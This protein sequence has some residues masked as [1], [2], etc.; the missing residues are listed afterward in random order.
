MKKNLTLLF[1]FLT[2]VFSAQVSIFPTNTTWKYLD[3]GTDQGTS[4]YAPGFNDLAWATGTAQLGYGESDEA[5]VLS[6][7]PSAS[8]KYVTHYFRKTFTVPAG[9]YSLFT[10]NYKVDDGFVVYVNG[11][12]AFRDNMATGAVNYTTLSTGTSD[13]GQTVR[14]RTVSAS[15]FSSGTNVIAVEVH[16]NALNS[17]DE[18][19]ELNLIGGAPATLTVPVNVTLFPAATTWKYMDDGTD[20]G[21]SWSAPAFNDLAWPTGT[22]QFGFGENDEATLVNACGTVVATPTCT[23]K[24]IT[25]YF[26]K[27]ISLASVTGY[28][29]YT[30]N[31]KRD[32]GI[33]V[34]VN[35]TEAFRSNM[36]TGAVNYT[37]WAS[38]A[39]SD[40]GQTV[41]TTTVP[42][43]TFS[44]GTN[45]IATELHNRDG[46]SSDATFEMELVANTSS[47]AVP[48]PTIVKGPYL[49]I[50][51]QN[52]M[53]IRW[54]TSSA[55]DT[56]VMYGTSA[57]SLTSVISNTSPVVSHEVSIGSLSAYTKYFYSIGTTSFV[58][59]GDTN[60]YFLTSPTPGAEGKYRFWV[61]G[62]CGNASTNQ[63]NVKNQ[64]KNYNGNRMVDGWLTLGD[65]AYSSGSDPQF[66]A[67]FFTIYQNDVM[68]NKVL[69]P[70]PGNHD[71]NNGAV[72]SSTTP[73][74]SIFNVPTA[75]EAGGVASGTK[76]YYSYDYGNI[77]FIALDSYGTV[78][79]NKM[80]DTTGAQAVWL[81]ADLAANTKK[82]IVA[83][84]HHP[85][86]TMG[87]HNSDTE[88]DLVAIRQKFIRIL[89]RY[90]VDLILCGHSHDYERSKLMQGHYG[91]ESTFTASVHNLSQSSALY[92]GSSNSCP[93]TKDSVNH[94]TGTVYVLS[95]SSGQ[96][97]GQQGS[98]PHDAMHYSNSTNGG[99]L[100]MD[101]EGNRLDLKW[102][103]A[104]GV[105]RDKFTIY[106]DVNAVKNYTVLPAQVA[107]L[108]ASWPGAFTWDDNSTAK[109]NTVSAL[110]DA[111]FWV[112]DPNSC[113]ADTFK[114]KVLPAVDFTATAPY[115]ISAPISFSNLSTNNTSVWTW[116]VSP[117]AGVLISSS[118]AQNPSITFGTA[119]IYTVSLIAE[120]TYGP[121]LAITKT[122]SVNANP[123]VLSSANATAI[124][125]NQSA[126]L[127][128]SGANSYVW[129]SGA[130]TSLVVV[131]PT[132]SATYTVTGTDLNGCIA[133]SIS[134]LVVNALPSVSVI[135]TPTS[136]IICSGGTLSLNGAGASS[137][138][139]TG[140][141]INGSTFTLNANSNYTLTGTDANGCENTA[142]V[143]IVV[144]ALPALS[145][146]SSPSTAMVCNGA[147][148]SIT[149]SGATSYSWNAGITNG[150]PFAPSTT[151][152]YTVTATDVNGCQNTLT[153]S[154]TVNPLPTVSVSGSS[155]ICIGQSVNLTAF[156][157][158]TYSWNTA[159]STSV[160]SV[161]PVTNSTYTLTGT[162]ANGC[163][164]V[165]L[166][167]ISVNVLPQV[168]ISGN[169]AVCLGSALTLSAGGA[170]SYVW[171]TNATTSSISVNPTSGTTYTVTG[172]DA[173]GCVDTE[174]KI[175]AVNAI[176]VVT[177]SGNMSLCAG[178]TTTLIANG[179]TTYLW[180]NAIAT[181]TLVSSPSAGIN[182]TVTG[183]DANG[184][185]NV[186]VT[187]FT[188]NALPVL[189]TL[190]NATLI[191]AGESATLTV[192]GASAYMWNT[193]ATSNSI[194]VSPLVNTTYSVTGKSPDNCSAS[195]SIVQ[196][197]SECTAVEKINS[198]IQTLI[199]PNPNKG[200]FNIELNTQGNFN[201]D[202]F[203]ALGERVYSAKLDKGTTHIALN[204]IKGIYFYVILNGSQILER[205]KIIIE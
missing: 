193:N 128:A 124:C 92:D 94:A 56:K 158:T 111:T 131:N 123:V 138:S 139:W 7:G 118:G 49:Q 188:V 83:Y 46:T 54:E 178:E 117:S 146:V 171:N 38:T 147:S 175:I 45:W 89:E 187:S 37:T 110:S 125:I 104:D 2:C 162:D 105:V 19:F 40:D 169:N 140:S 8:N 61:I 10:F 48:S 151:A 134:T 1:L 62:D 115:C 23:N 172:T 127:T 57:A 17:S 202:I 25:Q 58:I 143:A 67:E 106:K 166:K 174:M 85:P 53:K 119:G 114:L 121:G 122:I 93:Y 15:T 176:P 90:K 197:V 4:W 129:N 20:Q 80:Y 59:Q 190:S 165:A 60:N 198:N 51:T 70:V 52:S 76:A 112:K 159:A 200:A 88:S 177:L 97:G 82:W 18:T 84:W 100:V 74:F 185:S 13:D 34:Y 36:P 180:S 152:V 24:Y 42:A 6:Y 77:H 196:N 191:C 181:A 137:Y 201:A 160:I 69:W 141:I 113:V 81:K 133:S 195:T 116:S 50:G 21:T 32:D 78:A 26:R 164:N 29:A 79:G 68:K 91:A 22:A 98:F 150:V 154:V 183:T 43:N 107:T 167:T 63:V 65:N 75:A 155:A 35:G 95:G 72:T 142:T 161:S 194:V 126:S 27:S 132:L 102:L 153:Q 184:C 108:Q 173:N 163:Q 73:Y 199:Y 205:G 136:G 204:Q 168:T 87:S 135:T 99:S 11:T 3:D 55:C 33:I 120:N 39:V 203:N 5:T 64:F 44:A 30:F 145:V 96:L 179:A 144:N 14:T 157:A 148:I 101:I 16:Q 186:A 156:G 9:T 12:E 189:A 182:Y 170:A 103:C 31:Y 66:N 192:T 109:T 86:Y 41:I 149:A 130:T 71:Y 28:T 47:V